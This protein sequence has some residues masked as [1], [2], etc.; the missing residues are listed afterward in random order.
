M[1]DWFQVQ[2]KFISSEGFCK[3][4]IKEMIL[5]KESKVTLTKS[6]VPLSASSVGIVFAASVLFGLVHF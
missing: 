3:I 5:R 2:G 6:N 1:L 4:K